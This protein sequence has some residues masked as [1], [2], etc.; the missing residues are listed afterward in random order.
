LSYTIRRVQSENPYIPII[1]CTSDLAADKPIADLC[2][3]LKIECFQGSHL[4]VAS[5]FYEICRSKNFD[6]FVRICADSPMIDGAL[7]K[8]MINHWNPDLDLLTN[9]SPRT[10]PKGQSIEFVNRDTFLKSYQFF[11]GDDDFEHVTYYFHRNLDHFRYEN[12]RNTEDHSKIS[13]A[14]DEPKDLVRF[15]SFVKQYGPH[16]VELTFD[17]ILEIYPYDRDD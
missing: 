15:E 4:N 1:V 3:V 7:V 6:A 17:K 11:E 8:S 12:I 16:W 2:S 5:R 10:Y 14:I 9:K 13:L